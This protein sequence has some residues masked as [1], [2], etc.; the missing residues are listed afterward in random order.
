MKQRR[1]NLKTDV[2]GI[3]SGRMFYAKDALNNGLIDQIG[4]ASEASDLVRR[5][6]AGMSLNRYAATL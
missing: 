2:E 1:Q 5:L 3:L 6:S 4:T